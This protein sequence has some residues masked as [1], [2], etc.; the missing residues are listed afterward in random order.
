MLLRKLGNYSRRNRLY[1]AFRELGR[2]IRTIFLLRYISDEDLR[3]QI[4]ATTNKIES[5]H[6]FI[7]WIFFGAH[8]VIRH[9]DP[10]EMEKRIKYNDLVASAL[11]VLNVVD[12]T[13]ILRELDTEEFIINRDT[14]ATLSPYWTEHI[15][16]FGDFVID[17]E[18]LPELPDLD[19]LVL[20]TQDNEDANGRA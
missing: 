15:R 5:Y 3:W 18:T 6:R 14:L 13:G 2:V 20:N 7:E 19:P 4:T 12:M 10:L 8:G 9:N 16:R 17:L 11:I 1:R